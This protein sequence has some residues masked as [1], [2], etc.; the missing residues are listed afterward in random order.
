MKHYVFL[1]TEDARAALKQAT[2]LPAPRALTG[3]L[4]T[5]GT[6]FP[7]NIP[8]ARDA[9][10]LHGTSAPPVQRTRSQ[11]VGV[12]GPRRTRTCDR[13]IMRRHKVKRTKEDASGR[14]QPK[15]K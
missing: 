3:G 11:R 6:A 9:A 2:P 4:H 14:E 7:W 8:G 5:A 12:G 1:N 15:M 13:A 10:A